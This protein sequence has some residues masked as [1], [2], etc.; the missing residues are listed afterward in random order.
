MQQADTQQVTPP[1]ATPPQA[2]QPQVQE[3]VPVL[4]LA[5][6]ID[7]LWDEINGAIQDVLRS[8]QFIMGPAVRAFEEEVAAYLG[9]RHAVGVNS[10]TDALVIALRA[11]GVGPGDEV[12][13]TPFTFF[14]TAEAVSGLG[15]EP[16]FVDVD[17]DTFNLDLDQAEA[18]VTPRTKALLPVHLFGRPVDMARLTGLAERHGLAVVEDCAQSF[19]ARYEGRMTGTIGELGAYS[20]FPSKNLG[21]Y[22][23][24]GLIAT[25]DDAL[26]EAARM[27]RT[28]G[29]K[30]KYYNEV[31]GYNSRLD[32]LQAAV[33]RVKLPRIEANNAGRRAVARRYNEALGGVEGL[34][35]PEV[36]DGHVFHQYTVRVLG[37]RRDAVQAALKEEGI[38]TM[39]Y[40][41]VPCHRLPIYADRAW[42]LPVSE[43][44]SREVLS[45]PIWPG[46][47][48][49][50]QGR[51][52][53]A[54]ERA[55][56]GAG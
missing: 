2:T 35:V 36:V 54:V 12:V 23:D 32:A 11:L 29:S 48:E 30:R 17:P 26:A 41:P 34:V 3:R 1:Q 18:A 5:P 42:R 9:T 51:V 10:G 8:G 31:C 55:C 38:E 39:I 16:V 43:Q 44:L 6:E 28:H 13:T 20:F 52:I 7:A 49:G 24:G 27:L 15:A 19:G 47:P 21:A 37:G 33:L 4:D 45:L 14:A 22:G 40:Y 46:M 50:V 56:A 25:D 53:D